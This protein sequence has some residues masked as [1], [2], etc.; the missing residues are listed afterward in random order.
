MSVQQQRLTEK[1][2]EIRD[3]YGLPALATTIV[4]DDGRT[5]ISSVQGVKSTSL[6]ESDPSNKATLANY[7]NLGSISKPI[8]G[9]L[10][11]CVIKKGLLKWD[12]KIS[13]V[14]TEFKSIDF[15]N[16]T[17]I[18]KDFI[19]LKIYEIMSHTSGLFGTY[20]SVMDNE[21]KILQIVDPPEFNYDN[22][23]GEFSRDIELKNHSSLIYLRYH[24]AILS[25]KG[26]K[27]KFN[28]PHNIGYDNKASTG[29]SSANLICVSLLER[30]LNKPLEIIIVENLF[31]P[32]HLP[33][34][35]G[36]LGDG[37][38]YHSFSGNKYQS[39]EQW[40]TD[41]SDFVAKTSSGGTVQL[42]DWQTLLKSTL[43]AQVLQALLILL[44]T[45]KL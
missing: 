5:I 17:G 31:S 45:K 22:V 8:T 21:K 27:F 4:R 14:F 6:S 15:R 7:F 36:R 1:T 12:T 32:F 19:N 25:L 24:Y 9:F 30:L 42:K 37:M 13:D 28:Q 2:K 23:G 11:G 40:E 41:Y 16:R 43:E 34:K 35:L 39:I 18:N 26:K 33:F 20:Y 44:N 10:L 29:Y 3:K 38:R